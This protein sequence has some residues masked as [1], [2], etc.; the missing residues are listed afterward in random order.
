MSLEHFEQNP[1]ALQW[2]TPFQPFAVA[3]VYGDR[4][5]V[6]HPEAL[7]IRGGLAVSI[8]AD[9]TPTIFDHE[10]VNDPSGGRL[11]QASG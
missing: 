9:G 2:R 4:F 7:V 6:D 3:P 11:P 5:Q 8:A 1:R 10:G